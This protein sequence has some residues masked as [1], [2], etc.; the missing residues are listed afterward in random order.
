VVRSRAPSG[1][2]VFTVV[3]L[4]GPAP[5]GLLLVTLALAGLLV[6]I[7]FTSWPSVRARRHDRFER[8]H[9]FGGWTALVLFWAHTLLAM[10]GPFWT[11]PGFWVLTTITIS[12]AV[13]WLRLRKVPVTIVRPSSHVALVRLNYGVTPTPGTASAI[14][15]NPLWEWH[16]M[17]NVPA[18]RQS[19]YRHAVVPGG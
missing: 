9:R 1:F 13:P 3:L 8:T 7:V 12:S 19:G 15:R 10:N 14:S 4:T 5:A 2:S 11:E 18:P 16:G 17:A 6:F